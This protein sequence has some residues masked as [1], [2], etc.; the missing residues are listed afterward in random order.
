MPQVISPVP[1]IEQFK[2][3]TSWE[4]LIVATDGVSMSMFCVV[5]FCSLERLPG[6]ISYFQLLKIKI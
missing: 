2:I 6:E 5:F 1:Q 3:D 4:F